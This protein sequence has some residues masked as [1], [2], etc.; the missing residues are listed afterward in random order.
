MS[1]SFQKFSSPCPSRVRQTKIRLLRL[2]AL[3]YLLPRWGGMCDLSS[4]PS[5]RGQCCNRC[6]I[7]LFSRFLRYQMS[8]PPQIQFLPPQTPICLRRTDYQQP[9]YKAQQN[10]QT[11]PDPSEMGPDRVQRPARERGRV[12]EYSVGWHGGIY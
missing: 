9:T 5:T 1:V 10:Q 8:S 11:R 7:L 4:F 12:Y 6:K 3:I 2:H